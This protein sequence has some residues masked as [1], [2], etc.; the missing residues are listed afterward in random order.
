MIDT[1]MSEVNYL[2]WLSLALVITGAVNWGLEGLGTFADMNLNLVNLLL[3]Q[4]LGV[5]ELEAA[6]YLIIGLSGLYQIYFG[7]ELYDSQ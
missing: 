4:G 1:Q 2:D 3:T 5:P 7:Y 6:V